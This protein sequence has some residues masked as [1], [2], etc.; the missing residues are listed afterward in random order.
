MIFLAVTITAV[1]LAL[2]IPLAVQMV[3]ALIA[4]W[5]EPRGHHEYHCPL[6]PCSYESAAS[7]SRHHTAQH[8]DEYVMRLPVDGGPARSAS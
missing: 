3:I 8:T 6:C 7:L 4:P 1:C 5:P 2:A